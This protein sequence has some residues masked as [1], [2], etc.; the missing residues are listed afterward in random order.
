MILAGMG[1]RNP[2]DPRGYNMPL[3]CDWAN[4]FCS[5]SL[6]L[7]LARRPSIHFCPVRMQRQKR[8]PG[9]RCQ[10]FLT[11]AECQLEISFQ[12]Y[13]MFILQLQP[14]FSIRAIQIRLWEYKLRMR[15]NPE[16]WRRSIGSWQRQK[17]YMGTQSPITAMAP[18]RLIL[19]GVQA[20]LPMIHPTTQETT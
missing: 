6:G 19:I 17:H 9:L 13:C 4:S 20:T 7:K 2:N 8:C 18:L 10:N 1:D 3:R 15:C 5:R 14:R 12:I 11:S 16:T